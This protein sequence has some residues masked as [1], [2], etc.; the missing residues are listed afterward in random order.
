MYLSLYFIVSQENLLGDDEPDETAGCTAAASAAAGVQSKTTSAAAGKK[1][2]TPGVSSTSKATAAGESSGVAGDDVATAEDTAGLPPTG[3]SGKAGRGNSKSR[4]RGRGR[5]GRKAGAGRGGKAAGAG[6]AGKAAGGASGLSTSTAGAADG[7]VEERAPS[8]AA[9]HAVAA[10]IA[11]AASEGSLEEQ[12]SVLD[13]SSDVL[14]LAPDDEVLAELLTLQGELLQ[15]VAIN[16]ARLG[17]VLEAA[18]DDLPNQKAAQAERSKWEDDIV[19]YMT[20]SALLYS[21][22]SYLLSMVSC[23]DISH[24]GTCGC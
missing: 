15:Q 4:G 14:A 13:S 12:W 9:A 21:R 22:V 6:A 23:T 11:A 19:A 7:R 1:A 17:V 24:A 5:G 20:V 3:S 2:A 8:S 18:L 10:V 16:R